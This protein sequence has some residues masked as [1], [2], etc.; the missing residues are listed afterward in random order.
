MLNLHA[1]PLDCLSTGI[2]PRIHYTILLINLNLYP[3]WKLIISTFNRLTHSTDMLALSA[4]EWLYGVKW[5]LHI[6]NSAWNSIVST[7]SSMTYFILMDLLMGFILILTM[8]D[9]KLKSHYDPA[10]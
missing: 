3:Q 10:H 7:L 2:S 5:T 4:I 6:I 9:R 1:A 8:A